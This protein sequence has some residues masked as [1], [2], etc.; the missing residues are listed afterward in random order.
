V[1]A[2]TELVTGAPEAFGMH[3]AEL[4]DGDTCDQV[5]AAV[6]NAGRWTSAGIYRGDAPAVDRAAVDRDERSV[7][8]TAVPAELPVVASLVRALVEVNDR[9]FRYRLSGIP[10]WD[11]PSV[12][13]YD[14]ATADHFREH[15]DAGQFA[16]TRLLT[17]TVQLSDPADYDGG[18]LVVA[19]LHDIA[20]RDRGVLVTFASTHLHHVTPILRGTRYAIVGWV[21][22]GIAT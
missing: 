1:I 13:R 21:H 15:T 12:L 9:A 2:R 5:I 4:L 17:F 8:S 22:G 19:S 6:E 11:L 3:C 16:P 7:W 10:S 18:D 20:P 14:A